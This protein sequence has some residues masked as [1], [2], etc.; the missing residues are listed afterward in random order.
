M[1]VTRS[2]FLR[3]SAARKKATGAI[4]DGFLKYVPKLKQIYAA[5]ELL[6]DDI[7]SGI[8][9]GLHIDFD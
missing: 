2:I 1:L 4:S 3:F 6:V 5:A 7:V 8:F 9:F